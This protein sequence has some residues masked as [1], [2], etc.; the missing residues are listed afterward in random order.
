MKIILTEQQLRNIINNQGGYDGIL[1]GGLD[2][3]KGDKSL[4]EQVSI[5]Q[6][7]SGLSN[8]KGFGYKAPNSDISKFIMDN[9]NIPVVMFS[10]G[11]HKADVVLRSKGVNPNK[12]YLVQPYA[13]S[14]RS[15]SY[16]NDL[17]MP[18]EH[19]YVGSS[20]S[21]GFGIQ[22]ATSCPKGMG[23]WESLPKIGGKVITM[24]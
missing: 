6:N 8:I 18:K 14:S 16:F 2:Y 4:P 13:A 17:S 11:C 22:G 21:S 15:M 20:S 19:I 1:I 9:P 5:L 3:R 23:H 24:K 7:A 10:A 12:V